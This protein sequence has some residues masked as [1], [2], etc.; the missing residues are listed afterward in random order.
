[1]TI[2]LRK[3][4][5]GNMLFTTYIQHVHQRIVKFRLEIEGLFLDSSQWF[6]NN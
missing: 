1:M 4:G 5:F 6:N 3:I 2:D